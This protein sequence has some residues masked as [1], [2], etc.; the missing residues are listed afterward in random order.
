MRV[1]PSAAVTVNP[2]S[3]DP[4]TFLALNGRMTGIVE[5][6]LVASVVA[7]DHRGGGFLRV[8]CV[9]RHSGQGMQAVGP[10]EGQRVPAVAPGPAGAVVGIEHHEVLE[11]LQSLAEQVVGRRKP[12]LP[13]PDDD[14][15]QHRVRFLHVCCAPDHVC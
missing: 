2:S 6:V 1:R 15:V 12:G 5:V 14:G 3:I 9:Q 13:G 10:V 7:G 4:V 8:G 11:G